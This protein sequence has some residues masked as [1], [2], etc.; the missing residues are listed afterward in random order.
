MKQYIN[1]IATILQTK[2]AKKSCAVEPQ[3]IG[4]EQQE[5]N[6]ESEDDSMFYLLSYFLNS[7]YTIY[8]IY[9]GEFDLGTIRRTYNSDDNTF[10]HLF[11]VL[12][13]AICCEFPSSVDRKSYKANG[14]DQ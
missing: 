11:T 7:L 12:P 10:I 5:L 13:G 6:S 3:Y 9:V 1:H 14:M 8:F 4:E 2:Y